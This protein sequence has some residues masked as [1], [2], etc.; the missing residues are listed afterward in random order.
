VARPL[1]ILASNALYHVMARGNARMTIFCDDRE[2][3]RF[4]ALLACIVERFCVRCHAYCLM[5]NHYHLVIQT[6]DPN[7][8]R[9]IQYLNGVYAQWWNRRHARVGHVMQGRFKAQ[10]VQEEGYFLRVCRYVVLNPVRAGLVAHPSEWAW[11]SYAATEGSVPRLAFLHVDAVLGGADTVASRMAYRRFVLADDD[12][13]VIRAAVRDETLTI[14]DEAFAARFR[15]EIDEADVTE[16]P[17]RIRRTGRLTLDELFK[18]IPDRQVRNQR[19]AEARER[20]CYTLREIAAHL[21]LHY[22]SVSRIAA[23]QR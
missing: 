8:S 6:R 15:S 14:G 18:E 16:V 12:D 4:L 21:D 5:P 23:G 11:S 13:G 17:R 10:L 20:Y 7:L 19:I 22:A 3:L 1:R 9:A 2:R